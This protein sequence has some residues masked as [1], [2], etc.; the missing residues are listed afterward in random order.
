MPNDLRLRVGAVVADLPL[1]GT[2]QQVADALRRF[3]AGLGIS[4]EGTTQEQLVRVLEHV[5]DDVKRRA[6]AAHLAELE[7]AQA[8]GNQSTVDADNDL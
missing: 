8:A 6:K 7:A 4:T 1:G 3:A 2:T 5:R